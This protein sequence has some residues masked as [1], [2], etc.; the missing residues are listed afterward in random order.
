[1][2]RTLALLGLG[3]LGLVG[4]AALA[5]NPGLSA[6]QP[7]MER[8]VTDATTASCHPL[9][10]QVAQLK[11]KAGYASA[12]HLCKEEIEELQLLIPLLPQRDAIP[13]EVMDNVWDV[14]QACSPFG[15]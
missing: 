8:C 2:Q 9:S 11:T 6:L 12:S 10:E 7:A 13:R 3:G 5:G 1:M 14:Q 4:S 15:L